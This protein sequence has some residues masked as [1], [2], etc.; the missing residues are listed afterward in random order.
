[1]ELGLDGWRSSAMVG[2]V[3][4]TPD[5]EVASGAE[6]S[7]H[8]FERNWLSEHNASERRWSAGYR[9]TLYRDSVRR[10]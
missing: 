5:L 7:S 4:P 6:V 8:N 3:P 10:Y 1:M 9:F 2:D